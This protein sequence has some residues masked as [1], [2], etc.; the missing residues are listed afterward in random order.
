MD[1]AAADATTTIRTKPGVELSVLYTSSP[2]TKLEKVSD[3]E[4]KLFLPA[5]DLVIFNY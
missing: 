3:G 1:H 2:D 4:Y 5:T